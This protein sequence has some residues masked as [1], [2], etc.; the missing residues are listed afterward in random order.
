MEEQEVLIA[1]TRPTRRDLAALAPILGLM[2]ANPASAQFADRRSPNAQR[3]A[4]DARFGSI[5]DRFKSYS[6]AL[7]PDRNQAEWWAGAPSVVRDSKGVFWMAARMRNDHP[8]G[9]RGYEVRLLRSSDGIRFEKVAGITPAQ[10]PVAGFERPALVVDPKTGRLKLYG[11]GR[12]PDNRGPWV[13]FK[14]EDVD[15]L[16][17]I[18]AASARQVI[19]PV[20]PDHVR[21]FPPSGYKDPVILYAEGAFHCYVI[22]VLRGVERTY[23]FRSADGNKWQPVGHPYQ[24]VMELEA[25]HNFAV[26]PASVL[27]L[28]FGYLFVYEGS[29]VTWH[30]PNYNIATGL[31][32]T[33]DLHHVVDLTPEAPL[34]LSSTPGELFHTWRY[35][36]WLN[37][38]GQVWAY[39]EV[40]RPNRT[41][42]IRLFRLGGSLPSSFAAHGHRCVHGLQMRQQTFAHSRGS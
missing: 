37:V 6:V 40:A 10:V 36:T 19:E 24:A 13:V 15:D 16:A 26:R 38:D 34:L 42:E 4:G 29:H 9:P 30:D 7:E 21:D 31:G 5:A 35:S 22:G 17:R 20:K 23:H 18:D 25:W 8:Q 3:A 1:M 32:F 41:N 27:P 33:F 14:W 2:G 11:C 12:W 39:A 28:P